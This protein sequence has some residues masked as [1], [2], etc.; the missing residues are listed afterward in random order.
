MDQLNVPHAVKPC[1][2]R[3]VTVTDAVCLEHLEALELKVCGGPP[4]VDTQSVDFQ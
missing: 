4:D 3:V 2:G 1:V